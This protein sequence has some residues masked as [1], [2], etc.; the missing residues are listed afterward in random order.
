MSSLTA[1]KALCD[2]LLQATE[3]TEI[4]DNNGQVL[5]YFAPARTPDHD[6][7]ARAVRLASLF[8]SDEL[9]RRKA[10]KEPGFSF[11]QVLEHLASLEK[12]K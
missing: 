8:D 1:D 7:A 11:D 12:G 5:G 2:L 3:L 10:S 9:N 6:K 4:R